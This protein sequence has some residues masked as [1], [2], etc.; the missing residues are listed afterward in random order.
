MIKRT[1]LHILCASLFLAVA[2][3][4]PA[5]AGNI[6]SGMSPIAQETA[7][8]VITTLET[9]G[10]TIV[11]VKRTLLRRLRITAANGAHTREVIVSRSTGEI[12]RD[13][14]FLVASADDSNTKI[15]ID[16]GDNSGSS[17]KSENSGSGRDNDDDDNSGSSSGSGGG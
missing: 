16:D 4:S 8:N 15:L 9:S 5:A 17:S 10:Y 6:Y 2:V 13:S 3:A 14:V 1:K 7:E 11:S 12:R